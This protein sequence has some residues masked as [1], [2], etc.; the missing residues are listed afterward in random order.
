M[1][2]NEFTAGN[3]I[4]VDI[5]QDKPI[6]NILMAKYKER[7]NE[8]LGIAHGT[9]TEVHGVSGAGAVVAASIIASATGISLTAGW[10]TITINLP[11]GWGV[12]GTMISG[13][14][15]SVAVSGEEFHLTSILISTT[16]S[17]ARDGVQSHSTNQIVVRVNVG[18]TRSDYAFHY[19]IVK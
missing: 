15:Y 10:N 19:Q 13:M 16:Q 11:S 2:E 7:D 1:A 4:G 6:T 5:N 14:F 12:I 9:K 8:I 3:Q 17:L 18:F